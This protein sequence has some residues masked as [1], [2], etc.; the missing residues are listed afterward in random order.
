MQHRNAL[1]KGENRG[2]GLEGLGSMLIMLSHGFVQGSLHELCPAPLRLAQ[3]KGSIHLHEL[4]SGPSLA[5]PCPAL[6]GA[7]TSPSRAK[8]QSMHMA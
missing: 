5:R 4:C 3:H 1:H 8:S 2:G 6:P 7:R